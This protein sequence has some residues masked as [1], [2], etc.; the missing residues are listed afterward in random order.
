M[1]QRTWEQACKALDDVV[2]AT[3]D[4]RIMR[5]VEEFGGL[6]LMTSPSH[7]SGTD[8]CAEAAAEITAF[9]GI[10]YD[11]VINI[12]GDE[13]FIQPGQIK[14]LTE[15]FEDDKIQ[16]ATLAKRIEDPAEIFKA[17]VIKVIN[18]RSGF[19]IY[20]S[21]SPIPFIREKP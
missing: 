3:D 21:R 5:V 18:D 13:P 2:V 10:T 9:T 4:E 7:K 19:A 14:L 11:V 17:S 16:I 8:R 6:V 12:Q 1:I 15:C 20:F